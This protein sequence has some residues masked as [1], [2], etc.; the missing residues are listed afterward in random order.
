[1]YGTSQSE[2]WIAIVYISSTL[3]DVLTKSIPVWKACVYIENINAF[4][5]ANMGAF[6]TGAARPV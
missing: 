3:T 2:S 4:Q 6:Y 5:S 1:M